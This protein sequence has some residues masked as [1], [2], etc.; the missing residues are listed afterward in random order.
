[1]WTRIASVDDARD[2]D[3]VGVT[4]PDGREF[5]LYRIEGALHVTDNWC[6]HGQAR[7]SEGFVMDHC[8][9]CPLH[10]GQFDVRTGEPMCEPVTEPIRVYPVRVVDDGVEVD[11]G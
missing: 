5:A 8:V 1:M 4:A 6:T 10:Q 2:D 7:L 3:V 11:V 9:E